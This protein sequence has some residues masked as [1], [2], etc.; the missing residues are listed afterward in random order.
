M[1]SVRRRRRIAETGA[2]AVEFALV[3]VILLTLLIG[4][5]QYGLYFNDSFNARQGVRETVRQGVVRNFAACTP[6]SPAPPATTDMDKLL[7]TTKVQISAVTGPAYVKVVY[8]TPWAKSQPLKI[9]AMV[10]SN[11]GVGLVPMPNQG[12]LKTKTE[13]SIEQDSTPLP[14]GATRADTLPAGSGQD[15]SW[16]T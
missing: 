7:C 1:G 12:W 13:M 4:I 16:C 15:W 11:G 9:C 6:P 8:P 2:A 5:L 3:S 10:K 14:T